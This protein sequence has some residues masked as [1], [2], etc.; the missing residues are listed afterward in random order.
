M[1]CIISFLLL[2][3]EV[4]QELQVCVFSVI[5]HHIQEYVALLQFSISRT[6]HLNNYC[7]RL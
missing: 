2:L 5:F 3:Q 1:G 4:N 6:L 7:P